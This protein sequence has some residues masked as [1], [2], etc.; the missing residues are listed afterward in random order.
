[1]TRLSFPT[2]LD[3]LI[4]ESLR[5][6]AALIDTDPGSPVPSC[7]DWSAADLLWHLT[8]VQQFWTYVVAHRP[9]DPADY[10][11]PP[12]SADYTTLLHGFD[13]A[14]RALT[15]TL[16][17]AD[18][19]AAAW[20][21][22]SEQTVGFT[23]RR[24]ALEALVHRVDAEQASGTVSPIDP[25]LAAD[26]VDEV[27]TVFYGGTPEWANPTPGP[28]L[29]EVRLSDT[30]S[31]FLVR[32]GTFTGTSPNSGRNYDGEPMLEVVAPAPG[33]GPGPAP[34]PAPDATVTGA[35]ADVLLWIW[36]RAGA[37]RIVQTGHSGALAAFGAA[38]T[39]PL[40]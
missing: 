6:R 37:T 1:V 25:A 36:K 35:A 19:S 26:G 38:I 20:S 16:R 17:S 11:E 34:A 2:Y 21:W 24:Q 8:E 12:R 10:A 13:T 7:P 22:D 18:P 31:R 39:A 15:Q 27:L 33:P 32:P 29:V 4:E 3:H 9:A 5:F 28:H 14:T 40:D 30:D 23:F